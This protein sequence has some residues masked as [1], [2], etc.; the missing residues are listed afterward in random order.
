[1]TVTEINKMLYENQESLLKWNEQEG[2]TQWEYSPIDKWSTG[3]HI[4][5]LTQSTKALIK[6]LTMPKLLL[7]YRF[8]KCNRALRE[9]DEVVDKY[10][11]KLQKAGNVISPFSQSMPNIK[12]D[13]KLAILGELKQLNTK[14]ASKSLKVSEK[15]LDTVLLPHP[16]MGKMT[17]REILMWNAYHLKHHDII[18]QQK[19]SAKAQ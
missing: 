3:Q 9:Y 6:G 7:K 18:L 15:Y 11:V 17:L 10:H 16:L 1:M 19:Y 13:Q 2:K 12:E 4:L 5:H 14:L 8:G